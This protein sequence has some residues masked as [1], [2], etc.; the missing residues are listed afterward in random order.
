MEAAIRANPVGQVGRGIADL[1]FAKQA[2]VVDRGEVYAVLISFASEEMNQEI[3]QIPQVF[4]SGPAVPRRPE[5]C[6][7]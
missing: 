7:F 6:C 2:S 4:A 3:S 5:I 1:L